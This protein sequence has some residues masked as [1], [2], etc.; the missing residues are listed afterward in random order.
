MSFRART[1]SKKQKKKSRWTGPV[2]KMAPQS[3]LPCVDLQR[4]E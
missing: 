1:K 4:K 3:E 2:K